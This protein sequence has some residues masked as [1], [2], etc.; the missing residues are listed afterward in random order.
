[1][2]VN[3]LIPDDLL[4]QIDKKAE[5]LHMSRTAYMISATMRQ[6][7]QDELLCNLPNLIERLE[8]L[9]KMQISE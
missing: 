1:M 2:R 5:E 8:R 6:M 7:Q 4:K 9:E 3:M